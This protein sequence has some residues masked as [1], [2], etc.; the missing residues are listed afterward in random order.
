[1]GKEE[2]RSKETGKGA[3]EEEEKCQLRFRKFVERIRW[4]K[5]GSFRRIEGLKEEGRRKGLTL[6]FK[7]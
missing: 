1:V 3:K 7:I 2:G 4:R 6:K 5:E